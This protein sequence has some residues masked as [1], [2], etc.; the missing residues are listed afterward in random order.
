MKKKL[1]KNMK[2]LILC[3][4]IMATNVGLNAQHFT[5]DT[6][7]GDVVAA[8]GVPTASISHREVSTDASG[9]VKRGILV[10]TTVENTSLARIRV[11]S[12]SR[13]INAVNS[14]LKI[15]YKAQSTLGLHKF[16]I[17][18]DHSDGT[19]ANATGNINRGNNTIVDDGNWQTEYIDL[20]TLGGTNWSGKGRV[21]FY[22]NGSTSHPSTEFEIDEISFV[23]RTTA[24]GAIPTTADASINIEHDV[25]SASNITIAADA[26]YRIEEGKSLIIT[27]NLDTSNTDA[28]LRVDHGGSLIVSGTSTGNVTYTVNVL[29]DTD[30]HLIAS[31]VSG[32]GYDDDWVTYNQIASGTGSN[33]GISTYQNG[34]L[35]GTTGP[36]VYMQSTVGGTF[37]DGVGYSLK[38]DAKTTYIFTGTVQTAAVTPAIS[39]GV[40][41]NWNL[42]GNPFTNYV[43][44]A[45][46]IATNGTSGTDKLGDL[47]Q[48][49]Y[50][51]NGTT[52]EALTTGH[53]YPGQ[54]FFVNSKVATSTVS[55]SPE[56][57]HQ[58][59]A[60]FYKS[61]NTSITLKIS[62]GTS[63]KETFIDYLEG[64]TTGI[65]S[66]FDHGMFDGVSSDLRIFTHLLKNNTGVGL[67]K[68][69][70]PNSDFESL[71]VPVGV[72]ALAGKEIT[73]T[74]EAL[75][76][77]S[78][79][80]VFL[81]DRAKGTFTRLDEANTD[82]KTTLDS[83][84]DGV[85]RFYLHTNSSALSIE[86]G[87]A[88]QGVSIFKANKSTLRI[89]GL[90]Q[91]KASISLFNIQ[92]KE[93]F[94][95]LFNAT[96]V[97]NISLPQLS[98]GI[99]IAKLNSEK[100][101]TNKKIVLE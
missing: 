15:V 51:Y 76:L 21:D 7:V 44:I 86:D 100:G 88:L 67:V 92:G 85:G 9:V 79:I 33:R 4:A 26:T 41:S 62:N 65:D 61:S 25:T 63:T 74:A 84:L 22:L 36:W 24:D 54:A 78:G 77:P 82:Y 80:K 97:N 96:T 47:F 93:V 59:S 6:E 49:V 50:V 37:G 11:S 73:F 18:M 69:A 16:R 30:W 39:Q 45:D 95:T 71:V 27:G 32:E 56:T 98:T 23:T 87:L 81:E 55:I 14:Y 5:F 42:L 64:K 101:S 35:D 94:N 70:L 3:F 19:T 8:G 28:D 43:D 1:Q 89:T 68:Q 75:N 60:T 52:Y 66:G 40:G 91:G 10:M 2:N 38:N 99:Y 72:K 31:P 34:T 29:D 46:F 57:A 53:I 13:D 83:N 90:T 20:A 48:N 58:T 12:S 17:N